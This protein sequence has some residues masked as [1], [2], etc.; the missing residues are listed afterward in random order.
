MHKKCKCRADHRFMSCKVDY[1]MVIS[2]HKKRVTSFHAIASTICSAAVHKDDD[3]DVIYKFV[4]IC[5]V[6]DIQHPPSSAP[7]SYLPTP[8]S[9]LVLRFLPP[10]R[11]LSP[12]FTAHPCAFAYRCALSPI[13]IL[14]NSSAPSPYYTSPTRR[15]V[16]QSTQYDRRSPLRARQ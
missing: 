7:A 16:K 10:L 3:A 9:C 15:S 1:K 12:C 2:R 8:R 4:R 13:P 11:A 14:P 6:S 5:R